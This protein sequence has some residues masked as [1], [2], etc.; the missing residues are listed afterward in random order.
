MNATE[1]PHGYL[2]LD[3]AQ[4]ADD[5]LRFRTNVFPTEHPSIIYAPIDNK[6]LKSNYHTLHVL[7]TAAHK[8]RKVFIYNYNRELVNRIS[9]RVLNFLN[10][11]VKPTV[12]NKKKL[13][14]HRAAPCKV[15]D[16]G[17]PV[18]AKKNS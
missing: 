10:G 12:C 18:F 4:D 7:K 16:K 3:L 6:R 2:L 9:E 8:L 14:K 13:R 1:K 5:R 15:A 17:V 11:I